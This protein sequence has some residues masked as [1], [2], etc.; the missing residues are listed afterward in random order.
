MTAITKPLSVASRS[1]FELHLQKSLRLLHKWVD[2]YN[3]RFRAK[4]DRKYRLKGTHLKLA[5]HLFKLYYGL[6]RGQQQTGALNF[7]QEHTQL[8]SLRTSNGTLAQEFKVTKETIINW[9]KRL[10][11]AKIIAGVAWHGTNAAYELHLNAKI[12]FLRDRGAAWQ[13][14]LNTLFFAAQTKFFDHTVSGTLYPEYPDQDTKK[15]R[16]KSGEEAAKNVKNS[17]ATGN[18]AAPSSAKISPDTDAGYNASVT[19]SGTAKQEKN[20]GTISPGLRATPQK[21]VRPHPP[22]LPEEL[23]RSLEEVIGWL[24]IREQKTVKHLAALAMAK[25][26]QTVYRSEKIQDSQREMGLIALAEYIARGVHPSQYDRALSDIH[27]RLR[28][29]ARY[30]ELKGG[31]FRL[32]PEWYFDLRNRDKG[33]FAFTEKWSAKH[34]RETRRRNREKAIDFA[35]SVYMRTLKDPDGEKRKL[36]FHEETQKLRKRYGAPAVNEFEKLI[37]AAILNMR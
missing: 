36:V 18:S 6:L 20:R 1:H 34:Y 14:N 28:K 30:Y 27:L 12:L 4:E 22:A 11:T 16:N 7:H 31:R 21:V 29:A 8:P 19:K 3:E 15:R 5:E 33:G 37:D 2:E 17:D 25:A 32:L 24:P 23:P 9:R 13:G 35:V 10:T 26:L